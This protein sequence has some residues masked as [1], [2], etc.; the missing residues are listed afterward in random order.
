MCVLGEGLG[1]RIIENRPAHAICTLQL[2]YKAASKP[3]NTDIRFVFEE[4][5]L[6]GHDE[7][8]SRI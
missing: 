8:N 6:E 7:V 4:S 2:K 3:F 5:E 1:Q